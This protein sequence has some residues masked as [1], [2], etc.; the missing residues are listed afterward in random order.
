V[1]DLLALREIFLALR[2]IMNYIQLSISPITQ[3]QSE[4]MVAELSE[5]GFVAFEEEENILHAFIEAGRFEEKKIAG[6]LSSFKLSFS[7][8][9]IVQK[10]WNEE[11]EKNFHPVSVDDFCTIRAE[12]H[13]KAPGSKHDIIITP[14]MSFG[15]GHH[16]TTYMMI[17][18][19][20][21]T[22]F[23]GKTVLDF[24]TGTGVL[25]I[26]AEKCG[27]KTVLAID[28]DEWSIKNASENILLNQSG[29]ITVEKRDSTQSAG[30]FDVILANINKNIII[31][32]LTSLR[33]Q[34]TPEGV[35]ILSGFLQQDLM[36][37][38]QE[39]E[40][41]NLI[42]FTPPLQRDNW[43]CLRLKKSEFLD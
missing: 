40:K 1:V 41:N 43:L 42:I 10:N 22:D 11:W 7:K 39:A 17:E 16:A 3:E 13:P 34:L 26:L 5:I 23:A 36:D 14:K 2:R 37:F 12:F 20:R 15:T 19:M 33:Q 21:E 27:A 28:N 29:I 35:L 18:A 30:V 25:A 4:I 32:N 8:K 24:G 9:I 31:Q 38:E 6:I